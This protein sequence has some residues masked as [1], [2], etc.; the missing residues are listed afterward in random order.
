MKTRNSIIARLF[1][2]TGVSLCAAT[3]AWAVTP[4]TVGFDDG[5]DGGFVGNAFFESTGGNPDGN[6]RF[7]VQ[8]FGISL[9][10]GEEGGPVNSDF[11]GDYSEFGEVT[12]SFDIQVNSITNFFGGEIPAAIGISLIDRDVQGPSGSSGVFLQMGVVSADANSEWTTLS[13][14][15]SDPS[16]MLLPPGWIGFGDEDPNTFEPVL[17]DGA[18]FASVLAS[19]DEFQITTFVPGFFFTNSNYDLRIDNVSLSASPVPLP[20][21]IWLFGAALLSLAGRRKE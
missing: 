8:A 5:D 18:T 2:A 19:V 1:I 3:S 16:S 9:R 6:A 14:T 13:A 12:I 10:T 20:G 11:L 17:P 4:T 21:A 15:I 7:F